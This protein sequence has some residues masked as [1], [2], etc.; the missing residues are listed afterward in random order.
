[1]KKSKADSGYR[2]LGIHLKEETE[3]EDGR[4]RG[5]ERRQKKRTKRGEEA[6]KD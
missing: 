2:Q 5:R 6:E 4:D 1:M 3:G